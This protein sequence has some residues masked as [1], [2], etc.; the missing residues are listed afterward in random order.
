[1]A[2][3]T[4]TGNVGNSELKFTSSGKALLSFSVAESHRKRDE[5]GQWADDGAP[6]WWRCTAWER[7]AEA[8]A[9]QVT[10]GARVIVT[11]Q[12]RSRQYEHDGQ[13]KT[14]YD[15]TARQV[16]IIPKA[17]G[18]GQPQGVPEPTN[19]WG[20]QPYDGQPPF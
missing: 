17:Q 9:E 4:F 19:P 7:Q 11:G 8:L 10:K 20:T 13:T 12:V 14:S 16:G 6:T 5:A 18:Q 15:V 1:M 2:D 3:I